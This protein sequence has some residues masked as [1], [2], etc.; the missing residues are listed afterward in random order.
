MSHRK[1]QLLVGQEFLNKVV[2]LLRSQQIFSQFSQWFSPQGNNDDDN[3]NNNNNNNTKNNNNNNNNNNSL[4][5][6]PLKSSNYT[7]LIKD[8]T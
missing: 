3:N 6:M 4:I 5:K 1:L 7:P 2:Q 8:T